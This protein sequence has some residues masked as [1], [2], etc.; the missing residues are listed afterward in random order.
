NEEITLFTPTQQPIQLVSIPPTPPSTRKFPI[1]LL[2][3]KD[4]AI[5]S[6][7]TKL[8]SVI[9]AGDKTRETPKIIKIYQ[10][11]AS[12]TEKMSSCPVRIRGKLISSAACG[13]TSKPTNIKGVI[14]TTVNSPAEP[15]TNIGFICSTVPP[16]PLPKINMTPASAIKSVKINIIDVENLIPR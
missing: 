10:T 16:I 12:T 13:I 9:S 15:F 1:N 6:A 14:I 2:S 7:V 11:T 3:T 4:F 5:A 8:D